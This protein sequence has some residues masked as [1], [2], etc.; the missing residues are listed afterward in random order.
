M[1]GVAIARC[2]L[3]DALKDRLGLD[4]ESQQFKTAFERTIGNE[5][6][7]VRFL[8]TIFADQFRAGFAVGAVDPI[9]R[10]G[11]VPWP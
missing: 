4:A 7:Q 9:P 3:V 11:G 10:L 5:I 6:E 2:R 1:P 8:K